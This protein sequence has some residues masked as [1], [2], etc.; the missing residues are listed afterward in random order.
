MK[1]YGR[2]ELQLAILLEQMRREGFELCVSKPEVVL[3]SIGGKIQEPLKRLLL[4]S[5]R[6]LSGLLP[7]N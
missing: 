4:I 6:N 5:Q 1:V 3:K 2:G 7:K